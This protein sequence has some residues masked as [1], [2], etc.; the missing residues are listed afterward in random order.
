MCTVPTLNIRYQATVG[1]V[2]HSL[3]EGRR[4]EEAGRRSAA[5]PVRLSFPSTAT[6]A[7]R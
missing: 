3:T 6:F 1:L 2:E 4:G 7:R 5:F